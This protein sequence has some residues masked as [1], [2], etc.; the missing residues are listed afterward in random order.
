MQ[1]PREAAARLTR[2]LKLGSILG[3]KDDACS[4]GRAAVGVLAGVHARHPGQ[5]VR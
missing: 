5:A 2:L 4:R 3:V 1:E